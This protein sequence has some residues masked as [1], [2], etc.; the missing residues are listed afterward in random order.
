VDPAESAVPCAD[1]TTLLPSDQNWQPEC[2][3]CGIPAD[4]VQPLID[5]QRAVMV[6]CS[7]PPG[8]LAFKNVSGTAT[9]FASGEDEWRF[10]ERTTIPFET[11]NDAAQKRALD[12]ILSK[13]AAELQETSSSTTHGP[14]SFGEAQRRIDAG[15]ARVL[16]CCPPGALALRAH[17][18]TSAIYSRSPGYWVWAGTVS[19]PLS[20]VDQPGILARAASLAAIRA[21]SDAPCIEATKETRGITLPECARCSL[22]DT[23]VEPLLARGLLKH[24]KDE[25][26]AVAFRNADGSTTFYGKPDHEQR[27]FIR[28][29]D[30]PF[31]V[32]DDAAHTSSTK[33]L[34]RG[35]I[36]VFTRIEAPV[37]LA[38][39]PA[40]L[41]RRL[42]Y[43]PGLEIA[44]L[45]IDACTTDILKKTS[46]DRWEHVAIFHVPLADSDSPQTTARVRRILHCGTAESAP[47]E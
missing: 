1:R 39:V 41:F 37:G 5:A 15:T 3:H 35:R 9:L 2:A 12:A 11:V 28:H 29:T 23:S 46:E 27:G 44:A 25:G 43:C 13:R 22:P 40:D 16:N 34:L 14:L 45:A 26:D 21:W 6:N 38:N 10:I 30:T 19:A 24:L 33:E 8:V 47:K 42:D 4:A 17:E 32:I 31:D 20:D 36:P 7:C 18:C